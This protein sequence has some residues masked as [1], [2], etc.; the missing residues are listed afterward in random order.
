MTEE[1]SNTRNM[2][3]ALVDMPRLIGVASLLEAIFYL[4]NYFRQSMLV[5]SSM[6]EF[7]SRNTG[8]LSMMDIMFKLETNNAGA[9]KEF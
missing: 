1:P 5:H 9:V 7:S 4:P 2:E 8:L 6:V 3:S